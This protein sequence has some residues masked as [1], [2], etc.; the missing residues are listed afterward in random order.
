VLSYAQNKPKTTPTA[1]AIQIKSIEKKYVGLIS[2]FFVFISVVLFCCYDSFA[3]D[4]MF[5]VKEMVSL[6]VVIDMYNA[7]D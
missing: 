5:E 7:P 6:L 4:I 3:F 2:L 1:A